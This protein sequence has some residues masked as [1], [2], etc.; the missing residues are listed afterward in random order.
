MLSKMFDDYLKEVLA[1]YAAKKDEGDLSEN[2]LHP[3]PGKLRKE[4]LIVYRERSIPQD[5]SI[6]RL[7]FA[8]TDKDKGYTKGIENFNVDEFRQIP[9]ILRGRVTTPGVKYIDLLAWLIDFNPR[10]STIYYKTKRSNIDTS[11]QENLT[12]PGK[13]EDERNNGEISDSRRIPDT[14]YLPDNQGAQ[15]P[16]KA[17]DEIVETAVTSKT[18]DDPGYPVT[19]IKLASAIG[20][21]KLNRPV[22]VTGLILLLAGIGTFLFLEY[23][24]GTIRMPSPDEKC[25]YWTGDHYEPIK[26]NEKVSNVPIVPLDIKTLRLLKKINSFDTLTKNAIGKVWYSSIGGQHEFFTDSGMH[27]ID[28]VKKLRPLTSYI[29]TNHVS[30][31]R[32]L[33]TIL[34]WSVCTIIIIVIS[35]ILINYFRRKRKINRLS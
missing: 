8:Y 31:Y 6:L 3:T 20:K 15:I 17:S 34:V 22:V 5:D 35:A 11:E 14:G 10:P 24:P 21:H 2:L 18:P 26:C 13:I 12:V 27:P 29:L 1:A 16:V 7:F 25:M 9:K 30:Y 23:F 33:L 19:T 4:C 28:T 32:Y